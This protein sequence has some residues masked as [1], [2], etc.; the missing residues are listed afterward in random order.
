M[1]ANYLRNLRQA[2]VVSSPQALTSLGSG[3]SVGSNGSMQREF[4]FDDFKQASSFMNRY[5]DYC[6]QL[7]HT[8]QWFNVYNRVNVTLHNP[9][10]NGV[11]SKEVQIGCYLNTVSKATINQDVDVELTF[12]QIT[13]TANIDVNSLLNEQDEATTLFT[14]EEGKQS[15]SQLY[16]PQ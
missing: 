9:E 7:N 2:R 4:I 3:W 10:F 12:Q 14:L 11:T 16:L 13:A 15:K 6:S 8:P 1:L 5:A